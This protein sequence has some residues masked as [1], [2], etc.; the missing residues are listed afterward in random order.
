MLSGYVYL[1][2][3]L[4]NVLRQHCLEQIYDG[5]W[6]YSVVVSVGVMYEVESFGG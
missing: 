5:Q 1:L 6:V 3:Y 2:S 4:V